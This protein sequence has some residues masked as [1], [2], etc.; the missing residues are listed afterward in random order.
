MK[1]KSSKR[2]VLAA[3]LAVAGVF[4]LITSPAFADV[5]VS[6]NGA[7]LTVT[8]PST[9][10][11][12]GLLL[13]TDAESAGAW[14]TATNIVGAVP[15]EGG[16]YTVDLVAL[17]IT[18]GTP[19]RIASGTIY[20]NLDMLQVTA[21]RTFVDTGIADTSVYGV[22]FGFYATGSNNAYAPFIGTEDGY[23]S[24][25]GYY[26]DWQ[27]RVP[28]QGSNGTWGYRYRSGSKQDISYSFSTDSIN[29]IA[30]TNQIFTVGGDTVIKSGL[31][32]GSVGFTGLNIYLGGAANKKFSNGSLS[33]SGDVYGWWSYVQFDDAD[34]KLI[35]DYVPVQRGDGTVGFWDNVT[36]QFMPPYTD[37]SFIPGTFSAGTPTGESF[38]T[39]VESV[40]EFTPSRILDAESEDG[41][42]TVTVPAGL[43]GESIIVAWDSADKG[44]DLDDWANSAT[45]TDSATEGDLTARLG[46][47][48]IRNGDYA[49]VF[50]ANVYKPLDML[51][52]T[53][54][55]QCY[56]TTDF[57]DTEVYGAKL[58]FYGTAK[59]DNWGYF[60][61]TQEKD[62]SNNR[63]GGFAIGMNGTYLDSWFWVGYGR[64]SENGTDRPSVNTDSINEV[65]FTNS[66]VMVNGT[67]INKMST[68]K[69]A[70]GGSGKAI[71]IGTTTDVVGG[72]NPNRFLYGWWSHVSFYD[73]DDN[74]LLDYIPVQRV[75]DSKVGFYDRATKSFVTSSG[76]G[77]FTAGTV[78]NETPVVAVN[79]SSSAWKVDGIQGL[80][81]L[82]K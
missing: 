41:V 55:K 64:R 63:N 31:A 44:D 30:F 18:N 25:S 28:T 65:A 36:S 19:C 7:T 82:F 43:V 39:D 68:S 70:L 12:K 54:G 10:A 27:V 48:G 37:G 52:T 72:N 78:T 16:V 42:V 5:H 35:L 21:V 58:G 33:R 1:Q 23:L 2:T 75:S 74:T 47:L 46:R 62:A 11:G 45:L 40:C 8:A 53:S 59:A 3:V 79:A 76:T 20:N 22:R 73:V 49:R 34:G 14:T 57:T 71:T 4:G 77:N 17:G 15:S 56:I 24:S 66:I 81:I 29:E 26:G 13:Q 50:A 32:S 80:I 38:A 6:Q 61:G 69:L 67:M 51:Y 9:L 60:I